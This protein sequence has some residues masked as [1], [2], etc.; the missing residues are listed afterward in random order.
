MKRPNVRVKD[1]LDFLKNE[2]ASLKLEL[3]NLT[4]RIEN[5]EVL[6]RK[7]RAAIVD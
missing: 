7:P 1:E 2:M 5:L 4:K 3:Y 6:A